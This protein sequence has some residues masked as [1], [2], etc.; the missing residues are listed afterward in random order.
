ML[1][2]TS[3]ENYD[4]WVAGTLPFSSPEVK[5]A[6]ETLATI[7]FNPDYVYGE[8]DGI[9]STNFGDSPAA[10]FEDPPKCW[11]HKQ[12]NFITSFFPE[13]A[14][15]GVDYDIFYLPGIDR[16]RMR[17]LW[18]PNVRWTEVTEH[19]FEGDKVIDSDYDGS[20][21]AMAQLRQ[22]ILRSGE[23]GRLVSDDYRSSMVQA[24]LIDVDPTTGDPLDYWQLSQSLEKNIRQ[25]YEQLS[26]DPNGEPKVRIHI[27]GFAKI[28]G[29]LL[30]GITAI[31]LFAIITLLIT[32]VLLFA[33]TRSI[34]GTLS[35]LL[36]SIIA[37]VWQLGLLKTLGYGLNAYSILIPFLV[38]AIGV[39][40][41]VQM[42]SGWTDKM[43]HQEDR[44]Q[45]E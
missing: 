30:E 40:H 24:P 37:V 45:Y 3:L 13:G 18:T 4:A 22:N 21:R 5:N 11:L 36:C 31:V 10:M 27:I 19:G 34:R 2:T 43:V 6:A 33:Y 20:E 42:I 29:D 25:K 15:P 44:R 39:S 32:S 35:P 38:F 28:I 26:T 8:T 7:W 12:G 9:V 16:N 14:E 23:L 1:R 17:S 41:G